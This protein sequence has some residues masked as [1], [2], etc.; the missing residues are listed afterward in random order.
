MV[1]KGMHGLIPSCNNRVWPEM[2]CQSGDCC[3]LAPHQKEYFAEGPTS[4]TLQVGIP[5]HRWFFLKDKFCQWAY[6]YWPGSRHT[7]TKGLFSAR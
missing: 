4:T 2:T 1:F 5:V 7:G 3:V 6:R